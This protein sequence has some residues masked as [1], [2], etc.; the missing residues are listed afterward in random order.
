MPIAE[1]ALGALI[2]TDR[3][4]EALPV[5]LRYAGGDRAR[6]ALYAAARACAHVRPSRLAGALAETLTSPGKVTSRKEA[7]RLLAH[8]GPPRAMETLLEV[9]SGQD[10]HR[11][12]RAAIV[13]A[14][15]QRLHT[16]ASWAILRAA[17]G[18]S[19][20]ERRAVLAAYPHT[21]PQRYRPR[22]GAFV[23]EACRAADREIR[24][25]AFARL[26]Q[27]G[28]WL[29]GAADVVVERLADLGETLHNVEVAGLLEAGGDGVFGAALARLLDR[30]AGDDRL[31][32]PAA[33]R[34]ARRRIGLLALGAA[35]GSD[36]R[37][38]GADRS[39]LLEPARRLAGHP[40]FTATATGLLVGLGRLDNLD[41]IAGLCAGRPILAVRAAEHVGAR[42]RGLGDW[43]GLGALPA[44][45]ARL[46]R[47]GDLAGGL[48]AVALVRH[49]AG[50][51]WRS[52]WR[53]LVAQLRRH[54][55]VDVREE[56]YTISMSR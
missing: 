42:L 48:F 26:G 22:Y 11:D 23:L 56:A 29:T 8:Y 19:R 9:Y 1:A 31:D 20:E 32:D 6:V 47:R 44:T 27:W 33:D 28:P 14:A 30:D 39:A 10:T 51:G 46:A 50:Y 5:L 2:W 7:A 25:S 36:R 34:P 53:D 52:P 17:A 43:P 24:Q 3:P 41:E 37:P 16:E 54:P 12:V 18:G 13:S 49:G 38:A 55:D 4:D 15:R 21:V 35:A 40:S 45:V